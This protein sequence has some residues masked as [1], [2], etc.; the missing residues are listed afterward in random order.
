MSNATDHK[1][2]GLFS[3]AANRKLIDKLESSG[4]KV[5]Q[6]PPIET[7]KVI[8]NENSINYLHNLTSFDWI[9]FPDVFGQYFG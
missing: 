5:F 4:A 7:E 3:T 8:L 9:I 1:T 6:F 2:Y